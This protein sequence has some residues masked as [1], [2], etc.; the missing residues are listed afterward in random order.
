M[1]CREPNI[2]LMLTWTCMYS[3]HIPTKSY[4]IIGYRH[5]DPTPNASPKDELM[6]ESVDTDGL[7]TCPGVW[8]Y[9]YMH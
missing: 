8:R 1:V 7:N 2:E 3:V 4:S 9:M 6:A 5:G